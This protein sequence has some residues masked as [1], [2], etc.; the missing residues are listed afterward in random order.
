MNKQI[1][2]VNSI[3]QQP[4]W[5]DIVAPNQWDEA[6]VK[7][8]SDIIARM[9]YTIRQH[10]GTLCSDMPPFT[11]TLGPWLRISNAKYAKKL[12]E[13]KDLME[14]LI[15]QLPNFTSFSQRFSPAIT[16]W[17][18]FYW[19]GYKQT[20]RYTYRIDDLTN[21]EKIWSGFLPNIRT[22][23]RKAEKVVTVKND[24][25]I[26]RFLY[27]RGLTFKRQGLPHLLSLEFATRLDSICAQYNARRIF[28]AE[29]DKK[30]I[31]AAIYI[32]YDDKIAYYLL[33]G[34]DPQLRNSGATSLLIWKA[35][36]FAA[37]VTKVFDFEGSMIESVERFIRGFGALQYPYFQIS[38]EVE[39]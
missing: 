12:A 5:L 24:L 38:H 9:P 37:E 25:D 28:Y 6:I 21:M 34:G 13:Q 20:T 8:G 14:E 27:I 11:Q 35:I 30:Q 36:Q 1:P 39:K 4:W 32:V 3:F 16:N 15:D 17:L 10:N 26:E 23:I 2:Y 7:Q 18:P 31:H 22:D 19:R 33:S 29:D